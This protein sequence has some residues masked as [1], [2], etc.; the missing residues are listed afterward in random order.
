MEH[1]QQT[2]TNEWIKGGLQDG[3]YDWNWLERTSDSQGKST[4]SIS[5]SLLLP[6][7]IFFRGADREEKREMDAEMNFFSWELPR[8]YPYPVLYPVLPCPALSW[9]GFCSCKKLLLFCVHVRVSSISTPGFPQTMVRV[10]QR[11]SIVVFCS[12]LYVMHCFREGIEGGHAVED[13]F[14]IHSYRHPISFSFLTYPL[15]DFPRGIHTYKPLRTHTRRLDRLT[16]R[17]SFF[18]NLPWPPLVGKSQF[19]CCA[20]HNSGGGAFGPEWS[21]KRGSLSST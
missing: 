5:P 8:L 16:T 3:E 7:P 1:H 6:P 15:I 14:I 17:G 13:E 11:F 21:P 4:L 12:M 19:G 9:G 20:S 10:L 18:L 2:R